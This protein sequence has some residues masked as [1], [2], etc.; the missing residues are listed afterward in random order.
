MFLV[1]KRIWDTEESGLTW[2]IIC[3]QNRISAYLLHA[4]PM[5]K[6][7][8]FVRRL[9]R[10]GWKYCLWHFLLSNFT[11]V[12]NLFVCFT[13]CGRVS[14]SNYKWMG[15][16]VRVN[17]I[18][19]IWKGQ[20]HIFDKIPA[21]HVNCFRAP[22]TDSKIIDHDFQASN[23]FGTATAFDFFVMKKLHSALTSVSLLTSWLMDL[24]GF[25]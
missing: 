23:Y 11:L 9:K 21:N 8:S 15:L 1:N 18:Y 6:V 10:V 3:T 12:S 19:S 7:V 4:F 5:C 17:S 22:Q 24:S 16:K 20:H 2:R 25:S 14:I 13:L